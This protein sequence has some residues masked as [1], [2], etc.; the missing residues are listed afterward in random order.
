[1]FSYDVMLIE[2]Q[3]NE[4]CRIVTE[5]CS[6]TSRQIGAL[7]VTVPPVCVTWFIVKDW[8]GCGLVI[9]V[10]LVAHSVLMIDSR[11]HIGEMEMYSVLVN[12]F[13]GQIA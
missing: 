7:C 9:V 8:V 3:G 4:L 6:V 5:G 1:L 2:A 12:H 13:I 10:P 11:T